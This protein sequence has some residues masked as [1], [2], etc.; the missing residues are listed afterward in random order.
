MKILILT[1][2]EGISGVNSIADIFEEQTE[3]YHLARRRLMADT[4]TAVRAAFDAGAD[5]VFVVDGHG[6]ANNFLPGVLDARAVQ[7]KLSAFAPSMPTVDAVIAI[8][9][10]AMAGTLHAFLDHT[11]SSKTIH[12]YFYNGTPI[13]ELMQLGVYA[14][15]YGIPCVAVSGDDAACAEARALFG[16]DVAVASVKHTDRRNTAEC[17]PFDEAEERIY[18]AVRKGIANRDR[19]APIPLTLPLEVTVEFNTTSLCDD[20]C[21]ARPELVRV[22]GYC[23]RSVKSKIEEYHDVLL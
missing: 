8:G 5:E 11:Q 16:E 6:G 19:I 3:G 10:H 13:G 23:A 7:C 22:N 17:I 2:L 1:D 14:G 4:N 20:V 15:Y 18:W 9:M 12:N 21:A